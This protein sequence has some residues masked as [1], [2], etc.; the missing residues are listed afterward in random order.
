MALFAIIVA[1]SIGIAGERIGLK[2]LFTRDTNV[3]TVGHGLEEL[4]MKEPGK[5]LQWDD[6]TLPPIN[7]WNAPMLT[8]A[9][10]REKLKKLPE[11]DLLE[12]L[13]ITSEEL[14]DRFDDK[15]EEKEEYFISDLDEET[16]EDD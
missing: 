3:K 14:V 15:I 9:E 6:L 7:L 4:R 13:E 5:L 16:W 1:V 11:I 8:S 2:P 10:V 12:I